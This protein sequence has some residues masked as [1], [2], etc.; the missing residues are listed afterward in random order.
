MGLGLMSVFENRNPVMKFVGNFCRI[1]QR[2]VL[3][4]SLRATLSLK[5]EIKLRKMPA[6]FVSGS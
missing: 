4:V 3:T 2:G 6:I 1:L 5:H